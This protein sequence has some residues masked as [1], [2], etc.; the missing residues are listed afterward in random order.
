M[1][2]TAKQNKNQR[3]IGNG[4]LWILAGIALGAV[5]GLIV[6]AFMHAQHY[7]IEFLWGHLPEQL[8]GLTPLYIFILCVVGGL[9]V[10]L[11]RK[12]LGDEPKDIHTVMHS[13]RTGENLPGIKTV[14][15]AFL[16][17]LAS[18]GFGAAL[19]PEAALA[20]ISVGLGTWAGGV[21][22]RLAVRLHLE[23][24]QKP[25]SKL[26]EYFA[27]AS[28]ML[29]FIQASKS[30]FS[31]NYAYFPYDFSLSVDEILLAVAL[32]LLGYL[33]AQAFTW[34]GTQL[35]RLLEPVRSKPVLTSLLGGVLLGA[36]GMV[37]PLV[38]FS[39]QVG[40]GELFEVGLGMSGL[41]LILVGVLKLVAIKANTASG[42]KGGE[43]FPL[44]FSSSAIGLGIANLLPGIHPMV[45]IA[46]LM[47][48]AM[49][50][51]MDNIF[52]AVPI[53]LLFLP[54]D[55]ALPMVVAAL[56]AMLIQKK[57][58]FVPQLEPQSVIIE[59]NE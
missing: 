1:E 44:M 54:V 13:M 30:I 36:L 45:A 9:V 34:M 47:A 6:G 3:L 32:G 18:L 19:G 24:M 43:F 59:S 16:I 27:I 50:V 56:V 38:L 41:F 53:V 28:G 10:G 22:S 51:V 33:L 11:G 55:L 48:A 37:S 52:V 29:V 5:V 49:T 35:N 20:G 14:P 42:W 2:D 21:L 57:A 26:A 4:I 40:L 12:Y 31:N 8:G 25:W 7:V 15:A 39:G 23:D 58:V 17:S 46:A